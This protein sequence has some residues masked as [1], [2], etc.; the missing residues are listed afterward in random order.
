M[1]KEVRKLRFAKSTR[2]SSNGR[3]AAAGGLVAALLASSCCI[4]PLLLVLL[5]VSGAWIGN[6][7]ALEAYQPV[8][9]VLTLGFLSFG[10]W[11][12]FFKQKRERTDDSACSLPLPNIMVKIV[13]WLATVL[14]ALTL[15]IDFW[16]P[17]FY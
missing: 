17:F 3:V 5:G 9:L 4:V 8:F 7:R 14:V 16:A 11:Q 10:F 6:L 2:E 12:V 15:T 13:L 1:L